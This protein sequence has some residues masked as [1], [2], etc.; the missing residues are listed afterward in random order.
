MQ[1]F[2]LYHACFFLKVPPRT[3]IVASHEKISVVFWKISAPQ[4]L[5]KAL[6]GSEGTRYLYICSRTLLITSKIYMFLLNTKKQR[7]EEISTE[8]KNFVSSFLRVSL[9]VVPSYF[10]M[11]T[12]TVAKALGFP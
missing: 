1:K 3:P 7:N 2:D 10:L 4:L 6:G 9:I 8:L 5:G 12:K 11:I